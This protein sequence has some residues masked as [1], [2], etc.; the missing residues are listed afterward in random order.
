[1]DVLPLRP[2]ALTSAWTRAPADAT[3][4]FKMKYADLELTVEP[5]FAM[6]KS[7]RNAPDEAFGDFCFRVGWPA[8][9]EFMDS[10]SPGDHAKMPDP[11]AAPL[12]PAPSGSVGIDTDLLSMVT[13]EAG[14]R[15]LDATT[16]LDMIVREAL[17]A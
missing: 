3:D 14:A 10:Y 7:Q 2:S 9:K 12:L 13:T 6:Y 5:I 8:I 1:M 11:Y 17:E 16:L 15:G 4:I